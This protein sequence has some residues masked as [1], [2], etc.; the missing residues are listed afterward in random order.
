MTNLPIQPSPEMLAS[1]LISTS[2]RYTRGYMTR[3]TFKRHMRALWCQIE[4]AG[5]KPRV[6]ALLEESA[7]V[8]TNARPAA[9]L[10]PVRD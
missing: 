1:A 2:D 7:C 3:G 4:D 6:L 10:G 5:L 9:G 8:N